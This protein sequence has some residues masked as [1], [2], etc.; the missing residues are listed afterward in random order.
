MRPGVLLDRDGVLNAA[1]VRD[2]RGASPRNFVEFQLLPGVSAAVASLNC[3]GLPAI[4]VTNQPDIARGLLEPEQLARMNDFLRSHVPL[5]HIYTCIHDDRDGCDCRKPRPGL[6]LR[7]AA[8]FHLDLERSWMVG[9]SWRDIDAARAAKCRMIFVAGPH[10]VAG[11]HRPDCVVRS[12]PEAAAMI[13]RELGRTKM[14]GA[15]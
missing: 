14:A 8:E 6:L 9:D 12:L 4:V 15:R 13:L 11:T 2:G 5:E 3:A 1:V 7:A 10:A